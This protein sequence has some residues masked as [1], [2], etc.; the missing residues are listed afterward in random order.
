[1][2]IGGGLNREGGLISKFC[3][4]GG[5]VREGGLIERGGLTELLRYPNIELD[6][7]T[8]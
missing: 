7:P 2:K 6:T 5:I 3:L 1:M 4:K 8:K